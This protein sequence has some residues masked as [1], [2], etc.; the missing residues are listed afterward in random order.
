MADRRMLSNDL[1]FSERFL[2]M[3]AECQMLYGFLNGKTDNDGFV[4]PL[5][6]IRQVGAKIESF[7]ILVAKGYF[8]LFPNKLAMEKHWKINNQIPPSKYHPGT[9]LAE[10]RQLQLHDGKYY[11]R[12]KT[13][14]DFTA[15][16]NDITGEIMDWSPQGYTEASLTNELTNK[17]ETRNFEKRGDG[18]EK[19]GNETTEQ[20]ETNEEREKRKEEIMKTRE[21]LATKLTANVS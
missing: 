9:H 5:G 11:P 10:L 6:V 7:K 12:I 13:N 18:I 3:S 17:L 2:E 19:E 16:Q 8:I 14:W 1:I 21:F 20:T 4:E 15:W